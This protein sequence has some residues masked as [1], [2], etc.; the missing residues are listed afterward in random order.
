MV[1]EVKLVKKVKLLLRR[2]NIPRWL[3][4]F[5][6][7]TYQL[8]EHLC[9]L[10]VRF[11]CRLSYRRVVQLL[12]LLGMRCP[13]KSALQYTAK[14]LYAQFWDKMLRATSRG[15]SFIVALDSTGLSRT[16]PSYHY[17]NRIDGKLPKV[18]VKLSAAFGITNKKFCAAKARILP[19]HDIRDAQ[20]LLQKVQSK[21]AVADRAYN[22]ESLYA[23]AEKR[24]VLLMTPAKKNVKRGRVRNRMRKAFD[25]VTY[26]KRQLIESGFSSFK[27]KF[28]SSVSS[29]TVRTIRTEVYGRLACYNLFSLLALTLRT[30]PG[31][32]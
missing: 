27:R 11:Y 24:G 1:K 4:H 19:A 2:L 13:S 16:N 7:K 31:Q 22:A 8:Y 29:K 3:H 32:P 6:P 14:K 30:E 21:I 17:L 9:A 10:L 23:F 28:G 5:G 25:K 15:S 20:L 12:G 26:N 18:P